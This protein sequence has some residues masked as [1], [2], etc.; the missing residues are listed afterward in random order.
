MQCSSIFSLYRNS[1]GIEKCLHIVRKLDFFTSCLM[2]QRPMVIPPRRSTIN[3]IDSSCLLVYLHLS[4]DG[5]LV[6]Y[7]R[8]HFSS[9]C[10]NKRL[11]LYEKTYLV[12][13]SLYPQAVVY[14]FPHNQKSSAFLCTSLEHVTS[15]AF[16]VE[17]QCKIPLDHIVPSIQVPFHAEIG[18]VMLHTL[19]V[20]K[21]PED[22]QNSLILVYS[23]CFTFSFL[24]TYRNKNDF[25]SCL[26]CYSSKWM[27]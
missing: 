3:N 15:F 1:F 16:L 2:F 10:K 14:R 5:G 25:L 22:V 8:R 20:R 17:F 18:M 7:I 9:W 6:I 24:F 13:Q 21:N 26:L 19:H 4:T 11:W 23:P 12:D 27:V